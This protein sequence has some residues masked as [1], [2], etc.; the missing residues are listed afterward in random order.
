MAGNPGSLSYG[1]W[2]RA[3]AVNLIGL[4]WSLPAGSEVPDG[5]SLTVSVAAPAYWCPYA[6]EADKARRGFTVEIARTA[7][8]A[9]GHS[10]VYRNMPYDRALVETARGNVDA[11][12]PAFRGETPGFILPRHAVSVTEYCFY[13]SSDAPWRYA[14]PDSLDTIRFVATSG[15]SYAEAVD[16]HIAANLDQDVTLIKGDD[17]PRRLRELVLIG[18]FDA[19]LDDRLLLEYSGEHVG[20]VNAGCLEERH[21]GY[22]A[23]SPKHP[24]RSNAIARAFDRGIKEIRADGRLCTI[25]DHYGLDADFVPGVEPVDC[26]PDSP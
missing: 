20:L 23:L 3:L 9:S 4:F 19:L 2:F 21:T 17:I 26:R 16:A 25:L 11:I 8:E 13:V 10:I 24:D 15:Y 14:G 5:E 6:C 7:L 22:L 1:V 12:V 18:R